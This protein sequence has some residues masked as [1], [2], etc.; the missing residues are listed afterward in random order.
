MQAP[1]E[2]RKARPWQ[3]EPNSHHQSFAHKSQPAIHGHPFRADE[4]T[5]RQANA[6]CRRFFFAEPS[7]ARVVA[8]LAFGGRPR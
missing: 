2:M 4:L 8:A 7:T 3:G 1:P 6:I 5:A